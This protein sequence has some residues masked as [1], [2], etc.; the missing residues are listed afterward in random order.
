MNNYE[1]FNEDPAPKSE[2]A[3]C[4]LKILFLLTKFRK[5]LSTHLVKKKKLPVFHV[6]RTFRRAPQVEVFWVADAV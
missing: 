3:E 1:L 5:A 6:T 2:L 4:I